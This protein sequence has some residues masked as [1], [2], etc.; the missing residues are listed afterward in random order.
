MYWEQLQFLDTVEDERN[1][2][3]N[4]LT[5]SNNETSSLT[6]ET[7]IVKL[8]EDK[9]DDIPKQVSQDS[10][11]QGSAYQTQMVGNTISCLQ[12]KGSS[13]AEFRYPKSKTRKENVVLLKYIKERQQDRE[14]FKICLEELVAHPEPQE[15]EIDIFLKAMPATVKKFRLDLATQTKA[16]VFKV[17]TEM[18]L[19][20]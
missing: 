5:L 15:N 12:D 10:S 3:T 13:S 11:Y 8:E 19:L 16:N 2:F 18:E 4:V 1:T 14:H 6:V 17:I 20:N 7:S 9:V